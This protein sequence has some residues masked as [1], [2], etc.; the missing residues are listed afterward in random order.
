MLS[1]LTNQEPSLK[2]S[3]W[4]RGVKKAD[5]LFSPLTSLLRLLQQ[6]LGCGVAGILPA[7]CGCPKFPRVQRAELM[8]MLWMALEE[9]K[10]PFS[11]QQPPSLFAVLLVT[12]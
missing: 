8:Q 2:S 6:F 10:K 7:C 9:L 11:R 4:E 5:W 3:S 1:L 12:V